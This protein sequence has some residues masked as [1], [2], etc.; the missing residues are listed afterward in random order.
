[1]VWK[2]ERVEEMK[3]YVLANW[4]ELASLGLVCVVVPVLL[5]WTVALVK[6][7]RHLRAIREELEGGVWPGRDERDERDEHLIPL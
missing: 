3:Q 5:L 4:F 7:E 2:E 6:I 1:M